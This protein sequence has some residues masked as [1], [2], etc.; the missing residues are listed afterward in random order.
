[1]ARL[2]LR[3][4]HRHLV[5]AKGLCDGHCLTGITDLGRGGMGVHIAD[6]LGVNTS[7][8]QTEFQR[9][10]RACHIGC[11]DMVAVAG[12]APAHDL[13]QDGGTTTH[14]TLVTL[15]NHR[16]GTTARHQSVTVTVEGTTRL[17]GVIVVAQSKRLDAVERGHTVHIRLLGTTT[18]HTL[19]QAVADEQCAESDRL[20]PAG[21]GCRGGQVDAFQMEQTGQVHRHRRVHRLEDG[22]TAAGCRRTGIAELVEGDHRGLGH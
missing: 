10:G 20:R 5:V 2:T 1:M 15:Q 9:T 18:D 14:G 17:C 21:T 3:R 7:I 13:R 19:L 4:G 22:A 12:E 11:R 6:L 16:G 8:F